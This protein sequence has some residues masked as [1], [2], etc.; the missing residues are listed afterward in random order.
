MDTP[1]TVGQLVRLR[2]DPC[3]AGPVIEV[4]PT[5]GTVARYRIFHGPSEIRDYYADQLEA[6]EAL[7]A[8]DDFLA[9]LTA[10]RMLGAD[11][12]RARLTASRLARPQVDNLY[13]LQAARIKYIPFQLKPYCLREA[14]LDGA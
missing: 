7:H 11:V 5:V 12:F 8:P 2:A 13:A 9:A 3:K 10:G 14:H 4:L 1:F 6:A